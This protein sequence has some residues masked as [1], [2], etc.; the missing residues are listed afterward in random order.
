MPLRFSAVSRYGVRWQ[1]R[2]RRVRHRFGWSAASGA[3]VSA[4]AASPPLDPPRRT[5]GSAAALHKSLTM[6]TIH[7]G[8]DR[9]AQDGWLAGGDNLVSRTEGRHG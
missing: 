5:R 9:F 4:K 7:P 2:C 8:A 1:T 6:A 3:C